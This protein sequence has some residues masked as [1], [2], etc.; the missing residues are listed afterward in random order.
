M[1]YQDFKKSINKPYFSRMDV[2]LYDLSVFDYQL[3]LWKKKGYIE[4]VKRGLFVFSDEKEGLLPEEISFVLYE[5]SYLSLEFALGYY[6]IIPEMVFAKTAVT[7]KTTRK[8]SNGFGLFIYRH[9]Q[10][11]LFFG[12]VA[13]ETA[14]GKYL[15]AEPEK[16]LLDYL[17]FNLGKIKSEQDVSELR[18][19]KEELVKVIDREKLE[20]YLDEFGIQKL[21]RIIRMII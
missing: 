19:N 3:S 20:T 11:K 17:Y 9:I 21:E 4:S 2:L 15:L 7:T 14:F 10:P 12:Y 6:G 5:P 13:T 8:F 16:A 1:K 18:I